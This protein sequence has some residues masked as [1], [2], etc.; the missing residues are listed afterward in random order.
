MCEKTIFTTDAD[1]SKQATIYASID[2]RKRLVI[3]YRCEYDDSPARN[4]E[5]RAVVD[6]DDTQQM[7]AYYK[8]SIEQLPNLLFDKCGV[9]HDSVPS[10]ADRVF[11]EALDVVLDAM[12]H[13]KLDE[14]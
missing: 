8:V 13:Y 9:A 12:V 5:K 3:E 1:S 14:F 2:I 7:A 10:E 4:F 6:N 11:K